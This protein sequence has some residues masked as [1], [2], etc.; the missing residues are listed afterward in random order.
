MYKDGLLKDYLNDLSARKPAPGGGSAS[1][2]IGALGTGLL[3]MTANF[4]IGNKK[5]LNFEQDINKCLADL[6]TIQGEFLNLIDEDVRVYTEISNAMKTKDK[7]NIDNAL[8]SGYEISLKMARL[9]K[10]AVETA[11][12]LTEKGNVNLITDIGC[13][14]EFLKACFN[15]AIFNAKVNLKGMEDKFFSR[16]ELLVI[17]SA[18]KEMESLYKK[19]ITNVNLKMANI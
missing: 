14:A 12:E 17:T 7:K 13:A 10:K 15:S 1:A 3:E 9:S 4:T 11:L 5:Y 19:V 6:K 16:K 8:K 18:E 2:L